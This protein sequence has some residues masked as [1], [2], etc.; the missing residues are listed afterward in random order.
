R[1]I[2]KSYPVYAPGREPVGYME[3]LRSVEPETAFDP[4]RLASPAQ[5]VA[6]GEIVFNAPT[7]FHPVFF[8][9][10]D[11]RDPNFFKRGGMPIA[12]DGTIP[13]ARWVVRRKGSVELGS[14][15]C[16]TCNTRVLEDGTVVPGAQ[17]N[18]PGDRQGAR[19]LARAAK[20]SDPA[21]ALERM[22]G[23]ASQFE[24]PWLPDDPNRR[25]RTMSLEDLI[26]A[27]EA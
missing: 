10:E 22:R 24:M 27:G 5:W 9:A 16:N 1:V 6:A 25:A 14:M 23:F 21:K 7:S 8:S 18:N 4:A 13:F 2:Y 19:M 15:G 26:P 20:V 11:I 3:R 17:G 12:R